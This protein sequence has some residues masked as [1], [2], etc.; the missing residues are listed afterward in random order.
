[1]AGIPG[2]LVARVLSGAQVMTVMGSLEPPVAPGR[3]PH[4][5][6]RQA[7]PST[8]AVLRREEGE[9]RRRLPL[10]VMGMHNSAP[11]VTRE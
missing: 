5:V 6:S 4:P 2:M 10:P 1:M 9:G 8:A 11:W 3:T 7:E